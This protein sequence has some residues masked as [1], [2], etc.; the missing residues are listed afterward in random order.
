M[1][2]L[3]RVLPCILFSSSTGTTDTRLLPYRVDA[4]VQGATVRH[5]SVPIT[6]HIPGWVATAA[7]VIMNLTSRTQLSEVDDSY[8]DDSSK[9]KLL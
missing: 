7:L 2:V 3:V 4:F 6:Y 5:Q 9:V 1:V 8:E